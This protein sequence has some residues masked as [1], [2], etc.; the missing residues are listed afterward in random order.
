MSIPTDNR[1]ES[2]MAVGLKT[3]TLVVLLGAIGVITHPGTMTPPPVAAPQALSAAPVGDG[4]YFPSHYPAPTVVS[5][6]PPTF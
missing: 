4:D 5:E 1:P 3:A 2:R 6:Q